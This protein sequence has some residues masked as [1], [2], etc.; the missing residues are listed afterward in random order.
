MLPS[1]VAKATPPA[2]ARATNRSSADLDC[3]VE[4]LRFGREK[5]AAWEGG[6]RRGFGLDSL[7]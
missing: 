5:T 2:I 3:T 6:G 7:T 1:D 4:T